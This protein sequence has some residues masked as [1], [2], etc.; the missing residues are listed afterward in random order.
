MKLINHFTEW[1][2]ESRILSISIGRI[3]GVPVKCLFRIEEIG[4]V[5]NIDGSDPEL[6]PDVDKNP[7]LFK[8]LAEALAW[9]E[10]R[11]RELLG[12]SGPK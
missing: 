9:C 4:G 8:T 2:Y 10:T 5:F 6:C 11:E 7:G 12:E 1:V 3:D